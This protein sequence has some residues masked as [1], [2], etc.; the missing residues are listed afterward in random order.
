LIDYRPI[1]RVDLYGGVMVSNVWVGFAYG[2]LYT[3]NVD[4]TIGL[5]IRF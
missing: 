1:K 2:H 5:R 3:Q 4:P